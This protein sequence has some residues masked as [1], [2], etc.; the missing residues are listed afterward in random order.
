M[1]ASAVALGLAAGLAIRKSWRPIL[2]APIRW[3]AVLVGSL[4][5][6]AVASYVGDAGY[7]IYLMALLG[8]S[9]AAAANYKL[10]GAALVALGGCLNLATVVLNGGMPVDPGALSVVGAS[11]PHD[12]LHVL[13]NADTRLSFL[14]DVIPIGLVR[15]V[16]SVGDVFIAVGGFLVPFTLFVRR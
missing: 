11:M 8:T 1:L 2:E 6:R 14:A 12:A 15:S 4:L 10:T 3:P 16:Y 13:L 9:A 7:V 5:L